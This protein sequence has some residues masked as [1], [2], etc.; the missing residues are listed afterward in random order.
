[1]QFADQG[2]ISEAGVVTLITVVF[3]VDISVRLGGDSPSFAFCEFNFEVLSL[4]QMNLALLL[5]NLFIPAFPLD[6]GRIFVDV[7]LLLGTSTETAAKASIGVSSLIAVG[8][9]VWAIVGR[10]F[11][12]GLVSSK[13]ALCSF[14]ASSFLC[15]NGCGTGNPV[16]T[17][18][19]L[20]R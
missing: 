6:G 3:S 15:R 4:V 18:L 9:L 11:I 7:L 14:H 19:G 8:I 17:L 20:R 13:R 16:P 5:F 2:A 1:M 12:F 10:L